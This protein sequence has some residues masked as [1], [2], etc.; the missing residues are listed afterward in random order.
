MFASAARSTAAFR[1]AFRPSAAFPSA[2]QASTT[3]TTASPFNGDRKQALVWLTKAA[4]GSALLGYGLSNYVATDDRVNAVVV[5][6]QKKAEELG[7]LSVAHAFSTADHGLHPP[8]YHWEHSKP[9]KTYDHAAIRR[10]FQVYK[11]VCSACHSM[12]YIHYRNLVGV[13]HTS[14]EAKALA[15]EYEYTDGPNDQGEMFQRPGKLT[16]AMP[17]PYPNEEAARAANG[18]ALPPD[19][20][21]ISRARHGE[22]DYIFSL[23]L[24]Y[25][26]P[27]AGVVVREGLHYNPYFPGGAIAM[28]RA[29]YDEV[30]EYEDGTPN[31]AS[32]LAKDVSVFLSWASFPE[33]D[34]RKKMGVKT[35]AI[36]TILLGLSIWWKRFKWSYIK[37]RKIV[38]KPGKFDEDAGYG[39]ASSGREEKEMTWSLFFF[40]CMILADAGLGRLFFPVPGSDERKLNSSRKLAAD[41]VIYD[42][43]DSV[44]MNRKGAAR[45]LVF[46]ALEQYDIGKTEKTVRINAVGSGLEIDDLNV[47]LRSKYVDALVVPKVQSAKEIE[48]VSRMIDSIAPESSRAN[49]RIIVCIESALGVMNIREIA[50]ADPRI[51]GLLFAAEDYAA[52]TGLMRTSGR[53]EFIYARQRVAT[54][55]SAYGLQA[56]DMVCVDYQNNEILDAECRE[57]REWGFTGKQAIHPNQL[58]H[59]Q[60]VFSP[61]EKDVERANK[62]VDGYHE[63]QKKG[64]GAF[65]LDGKMIDMPVVKWAERLLAKSKMMTAKS[66]V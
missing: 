46:Q 1:G 52:D 6:A 11:E 55:A 10:G 31:N 9:W 33:H 41:S 43:E 32:Q 51:D 44:P 59:I 16:D 56:I 58:D 27:P 36:S 25:V 17:A 61:S 54:A 5:A 24:G 2:R 19:L 62:I 65:N 42:L 48:F 57:G 4:A 34:E 3:T 45:E 26:D 23:L 8:H 30:V 7:F 39:E 29:L 12:E 14:D 63:H 60:R 38:Y 13:S 49:I 66:A 21:C 22:E 20:S 37:T 15:E 47:V 28:A 35:I 50:Q 64:I 53:T 40:T 18:G